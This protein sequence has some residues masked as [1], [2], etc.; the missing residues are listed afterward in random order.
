MS[1]DEVG[2]SEMTTAR[3]IQAAFASSGTFAVG[4]A[5]PL[6]TALVTP[7]GA[8]ISVVIATSI[9]LLA[10]LGGAVLRL[11]GLLYESHSGVRW[12]WDSRPE[13]AHCS[14]RRSEVTSSGAGP[15]I[16]NRSGFADHICQR[17]VTQSKIDIERG[18]KPVV[19]VTI[20]LG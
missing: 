14:E 19:Y 15:E 5:M 11:Q 7:P 1:R 18:D 6:L 9:L 16:P 8:L 3:P 2:I 10:L 12:R 4:A 17:L 13:W 20:N